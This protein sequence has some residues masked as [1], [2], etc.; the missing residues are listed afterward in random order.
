MITLLTL[1]ADPWHRGHCHAPVINTKKTPHFFAG[2]F[3]LGLYDDIAP[4]ASD[5]SKE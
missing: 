3:H 2:V 1:P 4:E 5:D